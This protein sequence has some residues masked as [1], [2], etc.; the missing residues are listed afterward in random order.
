V[1]VKANIVVAV[2]V[3]GILFIKQ[4]EVLGMLQLKIQY[5]QSDVKL[6]F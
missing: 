3:V 5:L 6:R 2:V 4:S 1:V